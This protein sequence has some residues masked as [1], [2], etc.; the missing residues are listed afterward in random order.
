MST[1]TSEPLPPITHLS[2]AEAQQLLRVTGIPENELERYRATVVGGNADFWN[3]WLMLRQ[4]NGL[5]EVRGGRVYQK[6]PDRSRIWLPVTEADK[7]AVPT[8]YGNTGHRPCRPG[9]SH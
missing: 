5:L 7:I 2:V 8:D 6:K 4:R 3:D 1:Q 9:C